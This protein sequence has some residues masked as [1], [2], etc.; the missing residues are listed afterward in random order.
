MKIDLAFLEVSGLF[1]RGTRRGRGL[2]FG[3]LY[4]VVDFGDAGVGGR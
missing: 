3:L 1:L 4:G 2:R